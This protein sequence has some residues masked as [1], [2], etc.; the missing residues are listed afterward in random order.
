MGE[1][2]SPL[3]SEE[4]KEVIIIDG[5]MSEIACYMGIV[6]SSINVRLEIEHCIA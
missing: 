6:E 2:E 1:V 5:S 3:A 4:D